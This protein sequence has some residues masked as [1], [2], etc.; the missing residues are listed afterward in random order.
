MTKILEINN[1]KKN[2]YTKMGEVNAIDDLTFDV[3][4][5]EFLC[6]IGSSGCG[7]STL[8]NIIAGIEEKTK[9]E[10]KK[11]KKD[12]KIGYMLQDDSLFE[13]LTILDNACLGLDIRGEKNK[14][15]INYVKGLLKKY[16]LEEFMNRYPNE[17]SGGIRQR[18]V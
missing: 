12:L 15:N 9:G 18:V 4:E 7:K 6:I 16:G 14:E 11:L 13:W 2:Y 1:L 17:L 10:I 5:E 8:L 3:K